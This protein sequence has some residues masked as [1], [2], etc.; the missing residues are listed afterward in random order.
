MNT[1]ICYWQCKYK[2]LEGQARI[3]GVIECQTLSNLG[4]YQS[5][6]WNWYWPDSGQS[7]RDQHIQHVSC[8]CKNA[9]DS[10]LHTQGLKTKHR[11]LEWL[12]VRCWANVNI[13]KAQNR[14]INKCVLDRTI[15]TTTQDI[16]K[17]TN[18]RGTTKMKELILRSA[19]MTFV[20]VHKRSARIQPIV[21]TL[22]QCW[23]RH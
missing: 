10:N 8:Q 6:K 2:R 1:S 11:V 5:P 18:T 23:A 12:H 7:S 20:K 19:S 21:V 4:H 3:D 17:T 15:R 14:L 13:A 16:Y 9:I 22:S